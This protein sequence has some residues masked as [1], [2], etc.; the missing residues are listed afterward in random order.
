MPLS[1]QRRR[2]CHGR[3]QILCTYSRM[4]LLCLSG[5]GQPTAII[6]L[7]PYAYCWPSIHQLGEVLSTEATSNQNS[8]ILYHAQLGVAAGS[9]KSIFFSTSKVE[10]GHQVITTFFIVQQFIEP[11]SHPQNAVHSGLLFP[12]VGMCL[13]LN[14]LQPEQ[15]LITGADI[16]SQFT[17]ATVLDEED[18]GNEL[19]YLQPLDK[20]ISFALICLIINIDRIDPPLK[21]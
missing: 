6:K 10:D 16:V 12:E 5:G 18:P 21:D 8:Y 9:I 15:V 14:K 11:A 4:N 2:K 17:F 20:V 13:V 19:L 1:I 3:N 7:S